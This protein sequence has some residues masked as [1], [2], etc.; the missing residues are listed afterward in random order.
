MLIALYYMAYTQYGILNVVDSCSNGE[1]YQPQILVLVI[2][3][4]LTIT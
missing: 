1:I 2:E 3:Y 4:H